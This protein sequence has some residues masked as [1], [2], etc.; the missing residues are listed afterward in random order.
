MDGDL[1][2]EYFELIR[3]TLNE[4]KREAVSGRPLKRKKRRN[5]R[6]TTEDVQNSSVEVIDLES[7]SN[8]VQLAT[9]VIDLDSGG[10]EA[11]TMLNS[12]VSEDQHDDSVDSDEF[13]DVED[14]DFEN[15]NDISITI[16]K[17]E[18][19]VH[20]NKTARKNVCSN[21]ERRKRK[22]IHMFYLL[23]LLING[24]LRNEW[25][26]NS[27]LLSR[28]GDLIPEKVFEQLHP[29]K[30]EDMPL[31]ST[32]KLL[33]GLKKCMEIWN[34]H[35]RI[36]KR[37]E[38]IGCY[39]RFWDEFD[40]K[41]SG[42]SQSL[43]KKMF[44]KNVLKGVGDRDLAAQGFVAL[45]RSCNLN[46]RLVISMQPPDF[47]NLRTLESL[48]NSAVNVSYDD[49]IKYP[50]FWCEVWDKFGKK[51][52]TIDPI[53]LK[54]IEQIRNASKL[55]P[56]GGA[57][58]RRNQLRYVIGYDRKQG[59]RD[60]TR[61]YAQW[62]NSKTRKKRITKDKEG[63]EWFNRAIYAL[64]RRKRTKI[65]DYEDAYF[66]QRNANEGM[67]DNLQ[68]L[69]NH[70]YYI[71]ERDLGKNQIIKPNAKE[72]GYL[73]LN[74]RV[75]GVLKVYERKNV[76]NLK[77]GKQWYMEG[78]V[79]KTGAR[80]KKVIRKKNVR[81]SNIDD[82]NE[83]ERLYSIDDTEIYRP[84]LASAFGEITKNTFG[85][86]EVFV[87]SMIP[88]N[89]CL[90]ESPVAIKAAKFIGIEFAPAVTGF[91]FER[92]KRSKPI[93]SGV[94][95]SKLYREAVETAI[96][97]IENSI[98]EDE[99]KGFELNALEQWNK[100]L[101]KL[102]IKSQLNQVYGTVVEAEKKS[103]PVETPE[104]GGF[105]VTG[106]ESVVGP[107]IS[108]LNDCNVEMNDGSATN[109]SDQYSEGEPMG[110][111]LPVST[112]RTKNG[113]FEEKQESDNEFSNND[114]S[115]NE[116]GGTKGT[117]DE[118]EDFMNDMEL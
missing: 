60:I 14:T 51:W 57:P 30:D 64:N 89:C 23:C 18:K 3:K 110:G 46:A 70:P 73:K 115:S 45:L 66:D 108:N 20:K 111:F 98:E 80:C 82:D 75:H 85:N 91:K 65:D 4:K 107:N 105:F 117:D 19:P 40:E 24:F 53:N 106:S 114:E 12:E 113:N 96:A 43:N 95:V 1:P 99:R 56:R 52:I 86:I 59:T 15:L 81:L 39:M 31:R 8:D 92:G 11:I 54:T 10:G 100:F 55:E 6:S 71:L 48:S 28:L 9:E 118:Y 72:S 25:L 27:K 62:L 29:R 79:L 109:L 26:N 7:N 76:I 101:L 34:K 38:S 104:A 87:P 102:R 58:K 93:L 36:T 94:V 16:N 63:E 37:Y 69:K 78:R 42:Y 50:L 49:M 5:T 44:I 2:K 74:N 77:S 116:F 22:F 83:E 68:D 35:W 17:E 90:I 41:W 103:V 88:A 61:R 32:R 84:P 112:E 13:E 47:T 67:P 33:D 21:E 97:G